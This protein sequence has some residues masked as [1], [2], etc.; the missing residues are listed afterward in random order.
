MIYVNDKEWIK[1]SNDEKIAWCDKL[2][3]DSKLANSKR[4]FEW[5]MNYSFLEGNHYIFYNSVT[6]SLET[7]P[8]RK[9]E[10]RL[11]INKIKAT[12]RSI[13]NYSTR[14]QP[15]WEVIPD[16][17]GDEAVEYAR[18]MR[19]V[20]DDIYRTLNMEITI[21]GI[22]ESGLNTSVGFVELDWDPKG[23]DG[24]GYV[25]I[26]LHDSFDIWLARG[27]KI[28]DGDIKSR[29]IAKT[30]KR[31]LDEIK[32]D[33]R[34]DKKQRKEVRADEEV[35]T[36]Q[37]KTRIINK[38]EGGGNDDV[39]KTATVKEFFLWDDEG[40]D[41]GGHVQLFTYSGK[42]VLRD[43]ALK[44]KKYSIYCFQIP[45]DPKKIYHRTWTAD[46]IPL[47]KVLDRVIS[48]KVM[49][50]N[51]ALIYRIVAE[52]G[53]GVNTITNEQG[54]VVEVNKGRKWE[55]MVM[56]TLPT[57]VDRLTNEVNGHYEDIAGAHE[58]SL[59]TNPSGSRSGDMIE[60]LQ[61]GDSNNLVGIKQSLESFLAILGEAILEL[62]AE[63]RVSSK[64][65]Q[66][67]NP[68]QG[69][70]KYGKII[71]EAAPKKVKEGL[72]DTLVVKKK[73][74]LIVK[75]GSWLGHTMEAQRQRLLKMAELKIIPAEE[76]LRQF[77]FPNVEELS[78]KARE[79]RLEQSKIDAEIAGRN[80]GNGQPQGGGQN[81]ATGGIDTKKLA[82]KENMQMMN[83]EN[84]PPTEGAD[85]NHTQAH[86]DFIKSQMLQ[87][88]AT[89]NPQIA[90]VFKQHIQ[91]E[92]QAQ[93]RG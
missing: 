56:Q 8:R 6:N 55:Q 73:N 80:Q 12:N 34:Y 42:N 13:Q 31:A 82:D 69:E 88:A 1:L 91:G 35:A 86:V 60:A 52:K 18:Q 85:I 72:K 2:L 71:G 22:V 77:E 29:F 24:E 79:E 44:N 90:Q 33:G 23:D 84:I 65:V 76:I 49:Y 81:Q 7:P 19:K 11:V 36:S 50:V 37:M 53:H 48:Q 62:I 78:A 64:I 17:L 41:K 83:G 61:A 54:E 75:I 68:A 9:G 58:A 14:H 5:Y 38:E 63:H 27:A 59:G 46:L 28:K 89:Q 30:I 32:A 10:V 21:D 26:D 93:G 45:R 92:L 67:N 25:T 16:D 20:M 3:D 87:E 47:N 57:T 51:Q 15:K 70:P 39:I 40:N 4:H 43:E 74:K 66:M